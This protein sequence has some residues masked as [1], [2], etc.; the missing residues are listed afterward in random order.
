MFCLY[1]QFCHTKSNLFS[2]SDG[3]C[4]SPTRRDFRAESRRWQTMST[5]RASSSGFT[6]TTATTRVPDTQ[7]FSDI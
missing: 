5:P 6:R 3:A 2:L 1:D 7:A 4:F